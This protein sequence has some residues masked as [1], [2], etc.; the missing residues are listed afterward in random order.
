MGTN[1]APLLI[2]LL[3]HA[4]EADFLQGPLKNTDRKLAQTFKSSFSYIDD[5]LSMNN[6][7]FGDYL[8]AIVQMSLK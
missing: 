8:N 6:S 7:R 1:G 5:V 4:Y 3:Q 2:D